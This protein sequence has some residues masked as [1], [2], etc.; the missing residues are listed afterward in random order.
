MKSLITILLTISSLL[1]ISCNHLE[2]KPLE[3]CVYSHQF[4]K[5][6]CMMYDLN[7]MKAL[8]NAYDK[9]VEHCDDIIGFHAKDWAEEIKPKLKEIMKQAKWYYNQCRMG[10]N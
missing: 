1:L 9:P 2:I 3:R 6:R 4:N 10:G 7:E 5:C 8:S